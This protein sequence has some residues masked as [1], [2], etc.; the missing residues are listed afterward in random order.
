MKSFRRRSE[1]FAACVFAALGG[2]VAFDAPAEEAASYRPLPAKTGTAVTPPPELLSVVEKLRA[3]AEAGDSDAVF[4]L[5]DRE[6]SFVH[7]GITIEVGRRVESVASTTAAATLEKIGLAFT[8]GEPVGPGG[9]TF[10]FRA[11]RIATALTQISEATG[12]P[13]WGSDP[14]LPGA[15]CTRP[16]AK[17]DAKLAAKE[18][19]LSAAVFVSA[20]AEARTEPRADAPVVGRIS[21]GKLYADL[22]VREDGWAKIRVPD[23]RVGWLAPGVAKPAQPWGVCFRSSRSGGWKLSAVLSALN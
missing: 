2:L 12:D 14:L 9:Q 20:A 18:D 11:A 4:G 6:I 21:S 16:G 7:T 17:W 22:S 8:E 5:F 15:V 13:D 1:I 10:D 23:G 19:F 3:A